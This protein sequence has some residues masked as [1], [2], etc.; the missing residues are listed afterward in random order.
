LQIIRSL[1]KA[2]DRCLNPFI[3]STFSDRSGSV[4]EKIIINLLNA[5]ALCYWL[6]P[7]EKGQKKGTIATGFP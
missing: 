1:L 2:V 7:D 5:L 6:C 3:E 4:K